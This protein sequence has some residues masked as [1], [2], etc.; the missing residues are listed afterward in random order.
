MKYLKQYKIFEEYSNVTVEEEK[1]E[2]LKDLVQ[3]YIMDEYGISNNLVTESIPGRSGT[4]LLEPELH[5]RI[6]ERFDNDEPKE[7]MKAC[8]DLH[9]RVFS[10]TGL[11]IEVRWSSQ[12]INIMLR[13]IPN[14][15]T[16]IRDFNLQEVVADNTYDRST[17]GVCDWNTALTIIKYLNGFYEFVYRTD[18]S[19][20]NKCYDSLEELFDVDLIFSLPRFEKVLYHQ[21]LCFKFLLSSEGRTGNPKHFPIFTFAT[22][23]TESPLLRRRISNTSWSETYGEKNM[24]DL[25]DR[26][27]TLW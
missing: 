26:L 7:I 18:L 13:D 3:L 19:I 10:L 17:G 9:K 11:F 21:V 6:N 2:E 20:F 12:Q 25:C 4:K 23:H 24:V 27:T 14:H 15:Y 8:R 5:M 1:W 16:I 22:N